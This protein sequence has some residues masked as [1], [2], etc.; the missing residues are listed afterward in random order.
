MS[1]L[2]TK[3]QVI[4]ALRLTIRHLEQE[5]VFTPDD[6]ALVRLKAVLLQRIAEKLNQ[7][8]TP[9]SPAVQETR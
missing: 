4:N 6:P 9:N 1:G 5:M 2:T 3:A 8:S 7:Q